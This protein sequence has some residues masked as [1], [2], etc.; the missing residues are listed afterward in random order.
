MISLGLGISL[1]LPAEG[2][3]RLSTIRAGHWPSRHMLDRRNGATAQRPEEQEGYD[4]SALPYPLDLSLTKASH[5]CWLPTRHQCRMSLQLFQ[6]GSQFRKNLSYI[7]RPGSHL[8][9]EPLG[10]RFLYIRAYCLEPWPKWRRP[11]SFVTPIPQGAK[12]ALFG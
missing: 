1:T 4:D 12:A 10:M 9:S 5:F 6:F 8:F 2:V 11:V 7:G 3:P